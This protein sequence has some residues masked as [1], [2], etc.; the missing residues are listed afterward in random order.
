MIEKIKHY[1]F[2]TPA[3]VHDE[4]ALTALELCGRLGA[5]VN[6]IIGSVNKDISEMKDSILHYQTVKIPDYIFKWL[7]E[8]PEATTTVL[9]GALTAQKM[10]PDTLSVFHNGYVTPFGSSVKGDGV[11]DD[12]EALQTIINKLE[13][14]DTLFIPSNY[15]CVVT[16][17]IRI[18]KSVNVM[19]FGDIIYKGVRDKPA[20]YLKGMKNK[21]IVIQSVKDKETGV[22]HGWEVDNY[23]GVRF[24]NIWHCNVRVGSILNFTTG[25]QFVCSAGINEGF[26]NNTFDIGTVQNNKIGLDIIGDG[27]QS[28]FN[29]NVVNNM[30][31]SVTGVSDAYYTANVERYGIKETF[32]NGC[33]FPHDSNIFNNI[34]FDLYKLSGGSFT[35]VYLTRA[36]NWVFNDY[37]LELIGDNVKFCD[38]DLQYSKVQNICFSPSIELRGAIENVKINVI[39]YTTCGLAYNDIFECSR[40]INKP[41]LKHLVNESFS[42]KQRMYHTSFNSIDGWFALNVANTSLKDTSSQTGEKVFVYG[43]KPSEEYATLYESVRYIKGL[44]KGD[45]ITCEMCEGVKGTGYVWFK[46]YDEN[47]N[48]ITSQALNGSGYYFD[49]NTYKA[50]VNALHKTVTLNQDVDTVAVLFFGKISHIDIYVDSEQVTVR[51]SVDDVRNRSKQNF[52]ATQPTITTD[53]ELND[54]LFNASSSEQ[55]GWLLQPDGWVEF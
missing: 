38:L 42:G 8:H 43:S 47:G 54:I 12:T 36:I 18:E 27:V 25:I 29:A 41:H 26:C 1:S 9:D 45:S 55:N 2:T 5:K 30:W 19:W 7:D 11:T 4:E 39:N 33:E 21:I 34:K 40:G 15:K 50:S 22:Y 52:A 48:V 31:I 35:C 46:C 28:W 51:K 13:N 24:E 3:S 14:G 37:R 16:D 6:E 23:A 17:T 49:N 20:L 44:K 10:H 32:K 53:F